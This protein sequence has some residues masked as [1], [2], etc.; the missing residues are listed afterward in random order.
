MLSSVRDNLSA[1]QRVAVHRAATLIALSQDASV[2]RLGGD[3]SISF[4]DIT[5]LDSAAN[6]ATRA[7]NIV[8]GKP[9]GPQNLREYLANRPAATPA[10]QSGPPVREKAVP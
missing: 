2:R 10:G 6:R 4:E 8:P 9:A 7:L 5:R 3:L 1:A